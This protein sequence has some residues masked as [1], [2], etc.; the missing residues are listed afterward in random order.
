MKQLTTYIIFLFIFKSKKH[1]KDRL[2]TKLY[3]H[4]NFMFL[5]NFGTSWKTNWPKLFTIAAPTWAS[6]YSKDLTISLNVMPQMELSQFTN[7]GEK[8]NDKN[9]HAWHQN[10]HNTGNNWKQLENDFATK[11]IL[12][13]SCLTIKK[14]RT[15]LW[16]VSIVLYKTYKNF[17]P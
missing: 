16:T 3:T 15:L 12:K 1:L 2:N 17:M 14:K 4:Q 9:S 8:K 13:K 5:L 7:K 10:N 6:L 11:K